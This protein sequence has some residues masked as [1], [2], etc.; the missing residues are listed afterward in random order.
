MADDSEEVIHP[1]VYELASLG[2]DEPGI[3]LSGTREEMA[4]QLRA[5]FADSKQR[6]EEYKK[7][8][9]KLNVK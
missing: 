8:L 2:R 4:A 5:A 3:T 7:E 1:F 9:D 6:S